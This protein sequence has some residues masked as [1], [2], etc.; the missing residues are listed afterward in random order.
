MSRLCLDHEVPQ[1]PSIFLSEDAGS[2]DS[3]DPRSSAEEIYLP[4]VH[5]GGCQH[6]GPFLGP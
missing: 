1:G 5:I 6:Y 3:L 4:T 2:S